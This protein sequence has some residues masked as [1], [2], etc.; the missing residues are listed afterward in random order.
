MNQPQLRILLPSL[1]KAHLKK[2]PGDAVQ[3]LGNIVMNGM[4]YDSCCG[5]VYVPH[6]YEHIR[7]TFSRAATTAVV[8]RI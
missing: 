7:D 6:I 4:W 2:E 3:H 5:S 8:R 1:Q